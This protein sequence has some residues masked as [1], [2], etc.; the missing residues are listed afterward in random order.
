MSNT[1]S[2]DF[3]QQKTDDELRFF[4][5][6][7][8]YYQPSLIDSARR[9]LLRRGV[10]LGTPAALTIGDLSAP[11]DLADTRPRT[12]LVGL[13]IAG[14]L[15]VGGGFYFSNHQK[16]PLPPMPAGPPKAPPHLTEVA[17][18]VI[19]AFDVPASVT[20]Q[21]GR[22]PAAERAGQPLHQYREL[23]KRFWAAET[24]N[25][26]VLEQARRGKIS[27]ALA[28]HVESTMATWQQWN[29][30]TVYH[31]QFG[32]VMARHLDLMTRV[33]IQQQEGLADLLLVAKNPQPFEND[34]T[35]RR[36]AD[37]SDLLSG[38]LSA[39]PVTGRPYKTI[40]RR[41]HL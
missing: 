26:Y 22:V 14:A 19:P 23:T 32:P 15:L 40:V 7:P 16:P 17:T 3:Y 2:T 35:T 10:S 11:A 4:I 31:Y 27:P 13:L 18:S 39:S 6:H 36:A 28:G 12:R 30:A 37:V 8:A 34:K 25:E 20:R 9:E 41:V 33:A 24:Q 1:T 5:E 21:L 29:K 38:L